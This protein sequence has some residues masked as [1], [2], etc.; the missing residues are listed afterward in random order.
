MPAI[1]SRLFIHCVNY[2]IAGPFQ[3]K[4]TFIQ[5]F[6]SVPNCQTYMCKRGIRFQILNFEFGQDRIT[7]TDKFA[8][9]W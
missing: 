4:N 6:R 8:I 9:K 3:H 2:I 1:L 5:A 7:V